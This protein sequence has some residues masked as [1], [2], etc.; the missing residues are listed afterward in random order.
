[1]GLV[2]AFVVFGGVIYLFASRKSRRDEAVEERVRRMVS[3][4]VSNATF[5]DLYFDAARAYAIAKGATAAERDAASA[6]MLVDGRPY[7]VVFMRE[8][9]S[10]TAISICYAES[11]EREL[12]S[13]ASA[14]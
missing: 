7:F 5:H 1:M 6:T 14:R 2:I 11:V 13:F 12:L 8:R 3:G 4:G 10:S 9:G